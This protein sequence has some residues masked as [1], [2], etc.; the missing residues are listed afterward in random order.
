MIKSFVEQITWMKENFVSVVYRCVHKSRCYRICQ[1]EGMYDI[2]TVRICNLGEYP[3]DIRRQDS[4]RLGTKT[5]IC[6]MFIP[7][8]L[9]NKE[10]D[11]VEGFAPE[12]AWVTHGGNN[13][14]AERMCVQSDVRDAFLRSL[15]K[16]LFTHGEIF[17]SFIISGVLLFAGKRPPVLSCAA[18]SFSGRRD[19]LF[20]R[21]LRRLRKRRSGC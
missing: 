11:H 2:Q 6:R 21:R 9:L 4:R 13:P 18:A 10:K 19:I 1:R 15:C 5:S 8:S 20:M 14:L 12:V 17:R 3:K 16:I 7:E